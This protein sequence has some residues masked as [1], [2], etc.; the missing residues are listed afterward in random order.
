MAAVNQCLLHTKPLTEPLLR[1]SAQGK[2]KGMINKKNFLNTDGQVTM[3]FVDLLVEYNNKAKQSTEGVPSLSNAQSAVVLS[4]DDGGGGGRPDKYDKKPGLKGG[5]FFN[6]FGYKKKEPS[7][8]GVSNA[9]RTGTGA[10][11]GN[12]V[13]SPR[14]ANSHPM[15][16]SAMES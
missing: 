16:S 13:P 7:S 3:A 4:R 5:N 14:G 2:L 1:A 6:I 11:N 15:A 8:A 12:G 10:G 9:A